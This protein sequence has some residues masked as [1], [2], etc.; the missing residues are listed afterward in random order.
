MSEEMAAQQTPE[1]PDPQGTVETDWKAEARKWEQRAKDNKKNLDDLQKTLESF[2]AG[3]KTSE[4]KEQKATEAL[5]AAKAEI[6]RLQAEAERDRTVRDVAKARGVDPDILL[7]MI[8]E[9]SDEIE[10]N[11]KLLAAA[12]KSRWPDVKDKGESKGPRITKEEI[13]AEKNPKKQLQLIAQNRDL[14]K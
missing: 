1:T 4:E 3:Q 7:R 8:G 11:A 2:E 5:E 9:T 6:K 10:E 13:L 12:T 14:F